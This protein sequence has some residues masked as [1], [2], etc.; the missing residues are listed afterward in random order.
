MKYNFD[1]IIVRKGTN[2]EKYD[3]L[4]KIF[5]T[6]DLLPLWVADMDFKTPDFIVEAIKKRAAHEIYGYTIRPESY[7]R[8]IMGWMQRRHNWNIQ[9]EWISFSPG[10]VSGFTMAIEA[11]SEPGDE[12]IAQPPVYFPFFSSIKG[13]GRK[14]I[15]N[16]LKIE[17]GKFSFDIDDLESKIT[18]KTKLLLLCNPHN[19]GGRVWKKAELKLLSEIC[20][21]HNIMVIS[22]EIHS[23][24]VYNG[25]KHTPF[26]SLSEEAGNNC[27]V[28]MAPS[29]TFNVAG[30]ASSVAIIPNKSNFIRY[31]KR[32]NTGHFEAG[33]IF[34]TVALETAYTN[35]DEWL[36]QMLTYLWD[37]FCFL[38]E[39]ISQQLP[40][41]KVMEPEA[42]FLAWLD[43][44]DYGMD[45][46]ELSAF[47]VE[48]AKVGLNNGEIFGTGGNQWMRLNFGC[49]RS[50][51]Q[52]A[53]EKIAKAFEKIR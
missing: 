8:S 21:K 25:H 2:C 37:N 5:N 41:V 33:N 53:I 38:K 45:D 22:D 6:S 52:E 3:N 50:I 17:N 24:L 7:F 29:K 1:E 32:L 48:K 23:D 31:E 36:K 19:P 11:F 44:S 10:V 40:R 47:I 18:N 30:L 4:E 14:L 34:G 51:L 20:I 9:R 39:F 16:P 13:T 28:F 35:G 43:F 42:T 46:N 26:A 27:A 12:I 49:P 15:E